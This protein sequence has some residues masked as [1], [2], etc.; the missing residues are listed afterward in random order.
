[1]VIKKIKWNNKYCYF[2]MS[3]FFFSI[4]SRSTA[5]PISVDIYIVSAALFNL[6]R[7]SSFKKS[8]SIQFKQASN[9]ILSTMYRNTFC[10]QVELYRAW[11]H[12]PSLLFKCKLITKIGSFINS[13]FFVVVIILL[14]A[15][16]TG[17]S[18]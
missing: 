4:F 9:N 11:I 18:S 2:P 1:M 8:H 17:G 13:F 7:V 12:S 16:V 6:Y 14:H 3:C 10:I 15:M 5:A